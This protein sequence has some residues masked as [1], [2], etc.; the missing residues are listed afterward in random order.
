MHLT[1]WYNKHKSRWWALPLIL[2]TPL[3][4]LAIWFNAY[5]FLEGE[6]V[7]L[8]YMPLALMTAFSVVFGWAA[9]PG[10]LVALL[11]HFIPFKSE[12]SALFV[13][14]HFMIPIS[15]SL[16]G[17]RS[18]VPHRN[19]VIFGIIHLTIQRLF[20]LVLFNATLFLFIYQMAIFFGW[21]DFHM[22]LVSGSPLHSRTLINFQAVM[23]GCLTGVPF[24]TILS[25]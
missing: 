25:A 11:I 18:F 6:R 15:L 13:V 9:I 7:F 3:L 22:K 16:C 2:P 8:I 1:T 24:F 12:W 17:Y 4:S 20:W 5:T 23:V 19:A 10:I 21:Y 14:V